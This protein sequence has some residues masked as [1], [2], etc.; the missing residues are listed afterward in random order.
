MERLDELKTLLEI[1]GNDSDTLL[2]TYLHIAEAKVLNRLYPFKNG[3]TVPEKYEYKVIEIAQYLYLRRGSE[4]EVA[5]SENGIA[6]TYEN[7]DIPYSMISEIKPMV[8]V[9]R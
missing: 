2:N 1:T 9:P 6:R 4:G 5:H 7:A 3:D 8:G